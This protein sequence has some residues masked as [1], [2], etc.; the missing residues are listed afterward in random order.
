MNENQPGIPDKLRI[1]FPHLRPIN[2]PPSL[3]AINGC[4]V[5]V[6]GKRDF[7][8][9]TQTY[10]KT[11][12]ICAL[13]IPIFAV[14]AYRVADATQNRWYF[15]GKEPLSSFARSWNMAMGCLLLIVGLAV[16]WDIH[17]SSPA[18]QAQQEIKRAAGL[19]HSGQALAAAGIYRQ[20][21]NGPSGA[22][23][24]TGLQGALEAVLA[25]DRAPDIAAAFRLL[26]GLPENVNQPAPLVPD[27]FNRALTFVKKYAPANPAAALDIFNAAV[28]LDPKNPAVPAMHIDLLQQV[29]AANPDD[30]NHVSELAVAYETDGQMEKCWALLRPYKARLGATEGARILGQKLLSEQNYAD[31]YVLLFAY[32]QSRLDTLHAI[33]AAYKQTLAS[34]SKDAIADLNAGRGG[35]DFYAKYKAASKEQQDVMVDDFIENRTKSSPAYQQALAR[36]KEANNIVPVTLDLGIVQLNRAQA[37][38]DPAARKTELEAAEKTF[39]AIRSF[40]GESDEY[41]LFLGQVYYWLGKSKEGR[42]LFDQL[43]ASRKRN[44]TILMDIAGTLRAVGEKRDARTMVEEAY[45]AAATDKERYAAA[46]QRALLEKDGDD[47][48][49]WL[50]KADPSSDWVQIELNAARGTKALEQG[51]KTLAADF[52]GKASGGYANLPKTSASL[53]NWALVCFSLYEATGNIADQKHGMELMEEAIALDPSGSILLH[54]TTYS[55]IRQAAKNINHDTINLTALGEQAGPHVLSYLYR[56]EAGRTQVY[57]QLQEDEAMK[58]ALGYLDK[59]LLLAPKDLGLYATA[60]SIYGGFRDTEQLKKLQQRFLIAAPDLAEIR[61][62]TLDDYAGKKD[63]ENLEKLQQRI[64]ELKADAAKPALANDTM[65]LEFLNVTLTGLLQEAWTCGMDV[66]GGEL[67][68][69]AQATYQRHQSSASHSALQ[70]AYFFKASEELAQQSPDFARLVAQTRHGLSPEYLIVLVLGRNDPLAGLARKNE[71][72]IHA[73]AMEQESI[74]NFPAWA[75]IAGWALLRT[76]APEAA[77][78]TGDRYKQNDCARLLDE[79]QFQT[80]PVNASLTLEQYWAQQLLGDEKHATEIYQQALHDGVPLPAL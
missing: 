70:S 69:A 63:K 74:T 11:R 65:T 45:K 40:A 31:A 48:I 47:Q 18:Y 59:A 51:N 8:E 30:T 25:S 9:E 72:V 41:R 55:L 14:D 75:D 64:Q 54:N 21:L 35:E 46:G 42:E 66:N 57:R 22:D 7:D 76:T 56:D 71:N 49:E 33:E 60:M 32:V 5:R 3:V 44:Y 28:P 13:L 50:Q 2:N 38:S 29:V 20:Q 12:C 39:L 53:N 17:K 58:K 37:L 24:R 27:A 78:I 4:G 16:G 62:E 79:L 23:A 61:Q 26:A 43:L 34:I 15:L 73:V 80:S 52:F 10:V 1:K 67:L 19:M 68:A 6:Y 36:L 77:T